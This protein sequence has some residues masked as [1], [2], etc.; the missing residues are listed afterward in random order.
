M[1]VAARMRV[2]TNES[3]GTETHKVTLSAVYSSDPEDPNYSYSKWTPSATLTMYITNP[4]AFE[5]FEEGK[6]FDLV[7]TPQEK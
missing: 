1:A 6:V 5:Q 2:S 3:I 7:F 4:A